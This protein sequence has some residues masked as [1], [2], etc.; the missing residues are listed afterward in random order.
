MISTHRHII[1]TSSLHFPTLWYILCYSQLPSCS[2]QLKFVPDITLKY[3]H[4]S[5]FW[6]VCLFWNLSSLR[7]FKG[8]LFL[9][10]LRDT[11]LLGSS[12]LRDTL[13]EGLYLEVSTE[14]IFWIISFSCFSKRVLFI[15]FTAFQR[16]LREM[17][18]LA[19]LELR[20]YKV[21]PRLRFIHSHLTGVCF[22]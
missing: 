2:S 16:S 17:K 18:C 10:F 11:L 22:C 21:W 15:T 6:V 3:T 14:R 5:L 13:Y 19:S 9:G 4:S 7:V 20:T 1:A 12:V 8:T